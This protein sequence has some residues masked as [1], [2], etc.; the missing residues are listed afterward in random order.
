MNKAVLAQISALVL[1]SSLLRP[2]YHQSNVVPDRSWVQNTSMSL[3]HLFLN[4]FQLI[5]IGALTVFALLF[6]IRLGIPRRSAA[7]VGRRITR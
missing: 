5:A 3:G 4:F 1:F 7:F 6:I 2:E